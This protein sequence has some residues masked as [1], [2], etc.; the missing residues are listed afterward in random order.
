MPPINFKKFSGQRF[1][2][3]EGAFG[4]LW[5]QLADIFLENAVATAVTE[6]SQPLFDDGGCDLRIFLQPFR[7]VAFERIDFAGT[8]AQCR[9]LRRRIEILPDRSPVHLQMA[10][11]PAD[12][13]VLGPVE[14]VHF[15]DLISVKH[16]LFLY[17]AESAA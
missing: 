4:R 8:M 3:D 5:P 2:S 15:I 13:P 6:R 10:F 14:P 7:D 1:H 12:G 9:N 11:N 17:A 16:A